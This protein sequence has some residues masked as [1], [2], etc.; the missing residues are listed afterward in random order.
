MIGVLGDSGLNVCFDEVPK[1]FQGQQSP[2][3]LSVED[4]QL[5]LMRCPPLAD[6]LND[7]PLTIVSDSH[8]TL[9]RR[10]ARPWFF[11]LVCARPPAYINFYE[12][13]PKLIFVMQIQLTIQNEDFQCHKSQIVVSAFNP[14]RRPL[15]SFLGDVVLLLSHNP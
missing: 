14:W 3:R 8:S 9:F 11:H 2:Q 10:V 5:Q 13:S 15:C 6:P 12:E 4:G 1:I 7:Q